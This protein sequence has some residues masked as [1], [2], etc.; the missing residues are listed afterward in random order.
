MLLNTVISVFLVYVIHVPI[1]FITVLF[2]FPICLVLTLDN[3]FVLIL[4]F[5]VCVFSQKDFLCYDH[6]FREHWS[7]IV[8]FDS[9]D[10]L[11][12]GI[13]FGF[14]IGST[15]L[16]IAN[17]HNCLVRIPGFCKYP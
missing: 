7:L 14:F 5:Q 3:V 1:Y 6:L 12:L 11:F 10:A 17:S 9:K 4:G 13:I 2:C 16:F 15:E 8:I